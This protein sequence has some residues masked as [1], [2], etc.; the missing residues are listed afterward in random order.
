MRYPGVGDYRPHVP[1]DAQVRLV[2][3]QGIAV[4]GDE[5]GQTEV[6]QLDLIMIPI[7]PSD[8]SRVSAFLGLAF[9]VTSCWL[10]LSEEKGPN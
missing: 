9:R 8:P 3:D 5:G 10:T 7:Q 2:G 1:G 6:R 4:V